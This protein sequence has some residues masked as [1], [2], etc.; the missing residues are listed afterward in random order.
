MKSVAGVLWFLLVLIVA[1]CCAAPNGAERPN[2]IIILADDLGYADLGCYGQKQTRTPNLDQMAR[3]GRRF[4]DF[5]VA[6]SLCTPSRAALLTGC[7]AQRVGLGVCSRE[8]DGAI[9]PWHVLYPHS[10]QGLNPDEVTIAELLK[11]QGYATACIGKWHL[12]DAP[13]FMPNNQGFDYYYGIP[14]SNDMKPTMMMRNDKVIEPTVNQETITEQYTQ[15]AVKFITEKKDKPFFLYLAHNAPHTPLFAAERFRGKSPR[16][17]YGDVVEGLDW[18]VGEVLKTLKQ[19]GIDE[20]TLV[21]FLFDNGPWLLRGENGGSATPFRN[22]KASTYEGG[23]RVPFIARW[24]GAIPAGTVSTEIATAMDLLPTFARLAGTTEPTDRVIDG[25][26]ILP[27]LKG[28]PDAK[29]P[30]DAFYYYFMDELQGVRS[31]PWKLKLETTVA[32]DSLY[33]HYGDPESTVPEAL[34]NLEADPGEQ[35]SVLKD[36][37]QIA[38]Q[39]HALADRARED[40]GDTRLKVSGKNRRPAGNATLQK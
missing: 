29:T 14:Y 23:H 25:K 35:K 12:G 15:E 34:Y 8:K 32:N 3:E 21:V 9:V 31:G 28:T 27:L 10:R 24:P 36:H 22:G 6:S 17:L 19:Q 30:H 38:A 11:A 7:Y 5:Y 40:L 1:S 16:G 4:T 26:D 20:R 2:M 13:E 39:L 18:S 33:T 37:P